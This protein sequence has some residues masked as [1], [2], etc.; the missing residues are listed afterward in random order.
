MRAELE[1][2]GLDEVLQALNTSPEDASVT[3]LHF[4][5]QGELFSLF[6]RDEDERI[7]GALRLVLRPHAPRPPGPPFGPR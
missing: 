5:T 4:R 6:I 2:V 3:V 7:L 1:V